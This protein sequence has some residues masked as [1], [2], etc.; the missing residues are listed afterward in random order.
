MIINLAI[1]GRPADRSIPRR[2][3]LVEVIVLA[4]YPL[5]LHHLLRFAANTNLLRQL[6]FAAHQYPK[7]T[8]LLAEQSVYSVSFPRLY[9]ATYSLVFCACGDAHFTRLP[10]CF[11]HLHS[12]CAD[13]G[14]SPTWWRRD[15]RA[16]VSG[17]G[18][19]LYESIALTYIL[20]QGHVL[21]QRASRRVAIF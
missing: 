10:S 14:V 5:E 3:T 6:T 12:V 17:R 11:H 18:T 21:Q 16:L 13:E 9:A 2:R 15:H 1:V 19:E 4:V 20:R 8:V 7:L